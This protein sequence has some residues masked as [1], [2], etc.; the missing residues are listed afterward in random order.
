MDPTNEVM[1]HL[2]T[3]AV[4]VYA[5]QW[6]KHLSWFKWLS[7]DTGTVNR[8][9]SAIAAAGIAFG[10]SVTGDAATG[11]NVGI[12]PLVT[13]AASGYEFVKQFAVQQVLYDG[14]VQK[15]GKT[16]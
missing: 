16:A 10:I 6:L 5:I 7:D 1:T 15:A 8:I 4:V 3:G 12:P 11:W 14:V 13:L 9:V 2:T